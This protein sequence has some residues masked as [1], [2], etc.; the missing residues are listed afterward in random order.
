MGFSHPTDRLLFLVY[1]DR[2]AAVAAVETEGMSGTSTASK[3]RCC[4]RGMS[5]R[6]SG[7]STMASLRQRAI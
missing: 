3:A 4:C 6:R 5:I 7:T 1:A 2:T